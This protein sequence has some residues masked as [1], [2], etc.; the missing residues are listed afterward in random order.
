MKKKKSLIAGVLI[1]VLGCSSICSQYEAGTAFA[2]AYARFD[3]HVQNKASESNAASSKKIIASVS[4][5]L[6]ADRTE[7]EDSAYHYQ[8]IVNGVTITI[9]AEAGAIP[10]KAITVIT[11]VEKKVTKNQLVAFDIQ[12]MLDGKEIQPES[13]VSVSFAMEEL[14][15]DA[16]IFHISDKNKQ[17]EISSTVQGDGKIS[18][19]ANHFSVYGI[20]LADTSDD[21]LG[22][23]LVGGTADGDWQGN[24]VYY[25]WTYEPDIRSEH[26]NYMES[27][28]ESLNMYSLY[29]MNG[30]KY[31]GLT[32]RKP[33]KWRILNNDGNSLL[34]LSDE[35]IGLHNY[36]EPDMT[37]KT[38]TW[39]NSDVR[40]W[41]DETISDT[42]FEEEE[43]YLCDTL[44][45]D[46]VSGTSNITN[47]ND[48]VDRIFLPSLED[49]L[50]PHYGF[51][52]NG[53][54][55]ARKAEYSVYDNRDWSTPGDNSYWL[56]TRN[57]ESYGFLRPYH[58]TEEGECIAGGIQYYTWNLGMRPMIRVSIE[59]KYLCT[60][61]NDE[62]LS[63]GLRFQ[64]EKESMSAGENL[65]LI[66]QSI[67][68]DFDLSKAE[69]GSTDENVV[70]VD[71]QGKVSAVVS[72]E[73]SDP[74]YKK[75]AYVYA[76]IGQ[77]F[78]GCLITVTST[79]EEKTLI[80]YPQVSYGETERNLR[81]HF[82][83]NSGDDNGIWCDKVITAYDMPDDG[84]IIIKN[85]T[86]K[87]ID[88]RIRTF[89]C[90]NDSNIIFDEKTSP[91]RGESVIEGEK[92]HTFR[93]ADIWLDDERTYLLQV[94]AY[95]NGFDSP[96]IYEQWFFITTEHRGFSG[97][98]DGWCL[99]NRKESFG[100]GENYNIPVERYYDVF[101]TSITTLFSLIDFSNWGGNCFGLSL[102]SVANYN[103]TINLEKYFDT[104]SVTNSDLYSYGYDEIKKNEEGQYY[105]IEKNKKLIELIERAQISQTTAIIKDCEV[106]KNDTK[107]GYY[108][109][110]LSYLNKAK[111]N[112]LII[113]LSYRSLLKDLYGNHPHVGHAMVVNTSIQPE[114]LDN[115]W[116]RLYLYDS[117]HPG[118]AAGLH[119]PI[120]EYMHKPSYIEI[121]VNTG[122]W[123]FSFCDTVFDKDS[124]I[125]YL[126]YFKDGRGNI[127]N[128]KSISFFDVSKLDEKFFADK[129]EYDKF[130]HSSYISGRSFSI[131][132]NAG[133]VLAKV[134]DNEL[135]H[136]SD[137]IEF[138]P[139]CQG[140]NGD[141]CGYFN[142]DDSTYLIVADSECEF[143]NYDSNYMSY[144]N[145]QC[146]NVLIDTNGG[147]VTVKDTN[148]SKV[149]LQNN[150]TLQAVMFEDNLSEGDNVLV[151]LSNDSK[152]TLKTNKN[153]LNQLKI[154]NKNNIV[155]LSASNIKDSHNMTVNG[156][157]LFTNEDDN[158]GN[159]GT[160]GSG[161]NT[162]SGNTGG[163]GGSGSG[164]SS[165]SGGSGG[166]GG[167]SRGG[168][169]SSGGSGSS[170]PSYV[171]K[172]EWSILNGLWRFTDTSG[173]LK[174]NTWT[175]AYNPYA[176][177]G[178]QNYDWFRFDTN[179][180]MVTGW[181]T[182]ID[183]NRYFL[184]PV[185]DG[186]LGRMM[187]GWVWIAD[188]SGAQK[189]YYF[190]PNSD[191]Y[192]GKLFINM[193]V[194]G[195]T[196][197][198]NGCWTINGVV[199]VK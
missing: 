63:Y 106:F 35:L 157:K 91:Y 72:E 23:P 52:V 163:S 67:G 119:E 48:T 136:C 59:N 54:A 145:I 150:E 154:E 70:T 85:P 149:C 94:S 99:V 45:T 39:E 76:R 124:D 21:P 191:G 96:I 143:I 118:Y 116:Y 177:A 102:L 110:L 40:K 34:L 121:N 175:A 74:N 192:R 137:N 131:C 25:G 112:P 117:N 196:V 2:Q 160:S 172:G 125:T 142:I 197:D 36:N 75:S 171:E 32:Y 7:L 176:V 199:Q 71:N 168:G 65:N 178:Q 105:S 82:I 140:E 20:A 77:H 3:E 17:E 182:D 49:M 188:E 15:E 135:L 113:C 179:G 183:G 31:M 9:D 138:I 97:R 22:N 165:S 132:D 51:P 93:L 8:E 180:N 123:E 128:K 122:E 13:E 187:T 158:S 146:G 120:D 189:C 130:I 92:N 181:F 95:E 19:K 126:D 4:N 103:G 84:A 6:K 64:N 81:V 43:K 27:I 61:E 33:L 1:A 98:N 185:S 195:Y 115:G 170:L 156:I 104:V 186:T 164:G 56:R 73:S 58:V 139:Y 83:E 147:T 18:F 16:E 62:M 114:D 134:V 80:A 88:Y 42:F 162:N 109:E 5:L 152:L 90:S 166:G 161:N 89:G 169:R 46:R 141:F 190:N 14:P 144:G 86:S 26:Y 167:G 53:E 87:N 107:N 44:V 78:A 50:N 10:E 198:E 173:N 68:Q 193:V 11:P 184:N 60:S 28:A 111:P 159:A 38:I 29:S 41:L 24:Y 69:W 47:G 174:V 108:G 151:T 100:Y 155:D 101:G 12:F 55:K 66:L 127:N 148:K 57:S 194:D 37:D 79:P 153:T 129:L 30:K 133:T